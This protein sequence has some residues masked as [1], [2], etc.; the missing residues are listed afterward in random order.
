MV[1]LAFSRG[2][3]IPSGLIGGGSFDLGILKLRKECFI[4]RFVHPGNVTVTKTAGVVSHTFTHIHTH[5]SGGRKGICA[6]LFLWGRFV[7]IDILVCMLLDLGTS[8]YLY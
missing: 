6:C 2:L 3:L 8:S 4:W 1:R 7:D 5:I